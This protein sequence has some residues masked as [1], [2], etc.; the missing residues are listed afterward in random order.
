MRFG[1]ILNAKKDPAKGNL[2]LFE[3]TSM[4]LWAYKMKIPAATP[5]IESPCKY[6]QFSKALFNEL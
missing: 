1:G 6:C 3:K 4:S 2:S 5:S